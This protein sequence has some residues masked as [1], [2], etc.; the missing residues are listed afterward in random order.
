MYLC[1]SQSIDIIYL[2]FVALWFLRFMYALKF[3]VLCVFQYIDI[4]HA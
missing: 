4:V 3:S 1:R 2:A